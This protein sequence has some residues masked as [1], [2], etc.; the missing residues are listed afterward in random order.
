VRE[1]AALLWLK[2]N[3]VASYCQHDK[4]HLVIFLTR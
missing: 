2:F 1:L 3:P 4:E